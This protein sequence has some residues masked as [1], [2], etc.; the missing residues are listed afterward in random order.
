M[1]RLV[2]WSTTYLPLN[3][4]PLYD[5]LAAVNAGADIKGS[6]ETVVY[7]SRHVVGQ[8][9]VYLKRYAEVFRV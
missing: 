2:R 6:T 1:G 9:Y 7:R 3:G 5:D 4:S 8:C